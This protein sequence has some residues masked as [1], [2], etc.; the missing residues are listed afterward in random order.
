M[1]QWQWLWSAMRSYFLLYSLVITVPIT[2][3]VT[4]PIW[5]QTNMRKS[6]CFLSSSQA[7]LQTWHSS[8]TSQ[9][10]LARDLT[11]VF[12]FSHCFDLYPG[13]IKK[14]S[15]LILRLLLLS[16]FPPWSIHWVKLFGRVHLSWWL[17]FQNLHL[18]GCLCA[19]LCNRF[20]FSWS[21]SFSASLPPPPSSDSWLHSTTRNTPIT[22]L[23]SLKVTK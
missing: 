6:I 20:P 3:V 18:P 22:P 13:H 17:G 10:R 15:L 2:S 14:K 19:N 7:S 16:H 12:S 1:W 8:N 5:W 11:C 23:S 9:K 21:P 4:T